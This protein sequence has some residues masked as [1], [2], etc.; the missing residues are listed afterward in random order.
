[1]VMEGSWKEK[2]ALLSQ[3]VWETT[4]TGRFH[5]P[6]FLLADGPAGIRKLKEYF[7]EDIYNTYPCICYPSASTCAGSWD[8]ELL[9]ELGQHLGKEAKAEGIDVLLGPGVNIKRSPLGGRNFEYYSEDPYVTSELATEYIKGIQELGTGACIKHFAANNQE[10]RRMTIDVKV[11]EETL[12]EL[13]LKAFE[14]PIKEGKPYMVMTAYNQ[15][16]GEY[17]GEHSYLLKKVLREDWGYEGCVVTD[18][19]AAHD[20]AKA[21][22]NGLNLQMPGESEKRLTERIKEYIAAGELSERE[23]EQAV[24]KTIDMALQLNENRI[25]T[26]YDKEKHHV[27]AEKCALESMV[28]LKNKDSILPLNKKEKI[29][30]IGEMAKKPR[31]QGG[32]SSHVNPYKLEQ[33]YSYLE[34]DGNVCRYAAGYKGDV[35]TA[36]LLQE[37]REAAQKAEKIVLFIGLLEMYESEG[38]DRTHLSL[39]KA[40]IRLL[41]AVYEVNQNIVVV[42][43]CGAPVEMPW[44]GMVKGLLAAYLPGEAGGSAITK[45]LYGDVNPSGKL[46]ET[47]P[48]CLEDTPSFLNFPGDSQQVHY[49]EGMFVGYRYYDSKNME[50]LFP[51][52]YGLSYT[53]FSYEKMDVERME[54]NAFLG[55]KVNVTVANSGNREGKEIVQLYVSDK[56]SDK[57]RPQKEL[58]AFEKISLK[59]GERK[60]IEIRLD[61]EAFSHYEKESGSWVVRNGR[62]EI[63]IGTSSRDISFREE[64]WV[65]AG[66]E[67]EIQITEHTSL[68]DMIKVK[69]INDILDAQ[70]KVHPKSYEFYQLCKAEDPL[71]RS[72]GELMSFQTLKRVDDTLLDEHIAEIM[73]IIQGI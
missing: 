49:Q 70:L 4:D 13:Y 42:L 41:Q 43:S 69:R 28:L 17:C 44:I 34:K 33:A 27:F 7:D 50:P 53:Q 63:L 5:L 14:K 38:Y 8:R 35:T 12:Q 64:I 22:K 32:G 15:V 71:V 66:D 61:K 21:L 62:F 45:L 58:K 18:C 52:G 68:G 39:P 26:D 1:M 57:R 51:F 56:D 9:R 59:P 24:G 37:A 11:D 30:V 73:S 46:A 20:L 29:A 23:L 19:Y 72:M 47:F 36:D 67:K 60:T 10:T 31:F 6:G 25:Q 40:H 55:A 54:I 3:I 65:D 2:A 48:I 16:N